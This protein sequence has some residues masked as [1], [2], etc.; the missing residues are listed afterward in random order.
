MKSRRPARVIVSFRGFDYDMNVAVC[1]RALVQRQVA[2]E[3]DTMD[4]LADAIGRS[5]STTSRFFA[6]RQMSLTVALAVLGKLKLRFEDVFTPCD[7]DEGAP[8]RIERAK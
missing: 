5:R 6:G 4:G 3:F 1:R 7:P 2:G 8:T